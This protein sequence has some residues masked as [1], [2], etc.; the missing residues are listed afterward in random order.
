[1]KNDR[2]AGHYRPAALLTFSL[3]TAGADDIIVSSE[4][5]RKALPV[6]ESTDQINVICDFLMQCHEGA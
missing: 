4:S 5:V 3:T 2:A 6:F 1:M